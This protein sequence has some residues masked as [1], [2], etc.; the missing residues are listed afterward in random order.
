MGNTRTGKS[1]I[2]ALYLTSLKEDS[3]KP[4]RREHIHTVTFNAWRY[5]DNVKRA[6]LRQVYIA[7]G[8]NEKSLNEKLFGET[9]RTE[10]QGRSIRSMLAEMAAA[11]SLP[12]I[13]VLILIT[14]LFAASWVLLTLLG[15]TSE[16]VRGIVSA[17]IMAAAT[18]LITQI[19]VSAVSMH[20]PITKIELPTATAEQYQDLL[21]DQLRNYKKG[22]TSIKR[23]DKCERFVVFVD[24]LDRLSSEEMVQG[25]DAIRTFMEIQE[26]DL[27]NGLGI[28]FVISCD[29]ERIAH[30]LERG[31]RQAEL[32]GSVFTRSDARRYLDRIFQFRLEI[33]QFPRR[34]MRQYAIAKLESLKLPDL[35]V[36]IENV[37]EKM[38]HVGVQSP[39]NALQI[40]NAFAQ[41][42]WIA[43]RRENSEA[44]T[45]KP[46][47]LHEG[48]VTS[49]PLT[50]AA[51]CAL[52][53]DFPDFYTDLQAQQDLIYRF[54]GVM[55]KREKFDDLP[56][57]TRETLAKY[58][59]K[60]TI[61][62][63]KF[64]Y[65]PRVAPNHRPLRQF[66][67]T[68][69]NHRWPP[70]IQPLLLLSQDSVSRHYGDG[71]QAIYDA[72]VSG[73][74]EGVL[75]GLG[76]GT[77]S[78]PLLANDVDLLKDMTQDLF[79][80]SEPRRI[81]ASTVLA[82]LIKRLPEDAARVL[83]APLTRQLEESRQLRWRVGV[84][85]IADLLQT[86]ERA[87]KCAIASALIE[88]V[89]VI[90][91]AMHFML[92]TGEPPNLDEAIGI[93]K[94]TVECVLTVR[95]QHGLSARADKKLRDWLLVRNVAV[96]ESNLHEL[97]FHELQGWME[98]HETHLPTLLS[99]TYTDLLIS[100]FESNSIAKID[101]SEAL[102]LARQ[103][104]E[105]LQRSGEESRSILWGQLNRL[106]AVRNEAAL[107]LAW[108]TL[109][110]YSDSPLD[111]AYSDVVGSL[112][113]RL[114]KSL[115]D[116]DDYAIDNKAGGEAALE[117]VEARASDLDGN[118]LEAVR[119]LIIGW[120]AEDETAE[121]AVRGH[122]S[123]RGEELAAVLNDW[124]GRLLVDLPEACIDAV[125]SGYADLDDTQR[126][127]IGVELQKAVGPGIDKEQG[128]KYGRFI[129]K[130]PESAWEFSP[131]TDHLN[132]IL[133]QIAAHHNDPSNYL[134]FVCPAVVKVMRFAEPSIVGSM[135]HT[136]FTNAK[137]QPNH[138]GF[139]HSW[140]ARRWPKQTDELAPYDP[141]PIFSDAHQFIAANP[142]ARNVAEILGSM[143][144]M[145]DAG[146]VSA[147]ETEE[148]VK[149]ICIVWASKPANA[150]KAIT[151]QTVALIP[152]QVADLVDPIDWTDEADVDVLDRAWR[153]N[154]AIQT[155]TQRAETTVSVIAKGALGTDDQAL[156][157]WLDCTDDLTALL[158]DT[159]AAAGGSDDGRRRLWAQVLRLADTLGQDFF[160]Q[161][162]GNLLVLEENEGTAQMVLDSRDDMH[163]IFNDAGSKTKLAR[164]LLEDVFPNAPT[165]TVK[166]AAAAWAKS[167]EAGA[168]VKQLDAKQLVLGDMEILEEHFGPATTK[169]LRSAVEKAMDT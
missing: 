157:L 135:L 54:V 74:I 138:Y 62:D 134:Y 156:R 57:A 93:T 133:P 141:A 69:Q 33:P 12:L 142:S 107:T 149:S 154:S 79:S 158:T 86:A 56:E 29:E 147:D 119:D 40:V 82:T 80:E 167:L 98:R 85:R 32:P 148:L 137:G 153:H 104:F 4:L 9:R 8:G 84:P 70:S 75:E 146:H 16:W 123:L 127:A 17:V 168:L 87:E 124:I 159:F 163:R 50:L 44:G 100:E 83:V 106:A 72:L 160:L 164:R 89:L 58:F 14:L 18:H 143:Q 78:K 132:T 11:W 152:T 121:V 109:L 52:R 116:P 125:A 129:E 169:K 91:G 97:P 108:R 1:T 105:A 88:D 101:V 136:L 111:K 43:H 112:C 66:L 41:Y 92:T 130:L 165:T 31:R 65:G 114:S 37:V 113:G 140:M 71:K 6:L 7:L 13:V 55:S 76:H 90:K 95:E 36:G 131:L 103:Q 23:S 144:A 3:A 38:I 117:L 60:V 155:R 102:R 115:G 19:K 68:L 81:A 64:T 35:S 166:G 27:P 25:L 20:Q 96:D 161:S 139:L 51:L 128:V 26:A 120:S 15:V 22:N 49:H 110:R 67:A 24:D 45:D 126:A 151:N 59:E 77:D 47:A 42:W 150:I 94:A 162:I 39:R 145:L 48:A 28:V 63:K 21:L 99:D 61:D 46:G 2:K 34:D 122:Q 5:S 30:A 118:S 73:D 53:V 10:L